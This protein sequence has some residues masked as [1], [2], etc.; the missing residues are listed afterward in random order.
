[1]NF[2][3]FLRR[4]AAAAPLSQQPDSP[5]VLVSDLCVNIFLA[6]H[7]MVSA[8]VEFL[9]S[10]ANLEVGFSVFQKYHEK[11]EKD[12]KGTIGSDPVFCHFWRTFF[13]FLKRRGR[14]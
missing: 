4:G 9:N 5:E 7:P 14:I 13:D 12:L 8:P 3:G 6:N 2:H 11:L 1:M 10:R